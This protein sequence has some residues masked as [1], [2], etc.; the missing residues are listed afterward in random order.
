[1]DFIKGLVVISKTGRDEG[2]FYMVV[3]IEDEFIWVADGKRK[4]MS[5]PKRKNIKHLL[6]T[7]EKV[8]TS[9]DTTNKQ[10]SLMLNDIRLKTQKEGRSYV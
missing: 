6:I 7:S 3:R 9:V 4:K 2:Q 1:M 10:L 5:D 8:D